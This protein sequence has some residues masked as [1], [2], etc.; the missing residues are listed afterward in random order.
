MSKIP[1]S[2]SAKIADSN[3]P[4]LFRAQLTLELCQ[5]C[6]ERNCDKLLHAGQNIITKMNNGTKTVVLRRL[7]GTG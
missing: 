3:S 1:K 7:L 5:L 4:N 6:W 2:N